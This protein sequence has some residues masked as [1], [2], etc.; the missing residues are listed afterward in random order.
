[1]GMPEPE[2]GAARGSGAKAPAGPRPLA[3]SHWEWIAAAA[4]LLLVL[5]AI[6]FL[7]FDARNSP[8]SAPSIR[9]A[10]DSIITA[11]D[12]LLVEFHARNAGT[13]TAAGVRVEGRLSSDS[14]VVETSEVTLDYV[15]GESARSA[16]LFFSLD[17]R[18]HR[19]DIRPT[20][21]ERP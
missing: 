9:I 10:I 5:G 6:G 19:L 12:G 14:G 7:L 3:G 8:R 20:G 15:P 11:G 4:S 13:T 2:K 18:E 21:Y 16:G 17:P 1:M